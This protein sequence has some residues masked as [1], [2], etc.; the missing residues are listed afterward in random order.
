MA[1]K[2]KLYP[3][4]AQAEEQRNK[5]N[6]S[7]YDCVPNWEKYGYKNEQEYLD[8]ELHWTQEKILV[9]LNID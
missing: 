6:F 1:H 7:S 5:K 9:W 4:I 3:G 8:K 2:K